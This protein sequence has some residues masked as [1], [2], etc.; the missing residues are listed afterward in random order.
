MLRLIYTPHY[1]WHHGQQ[2]VQEFLREDKDRIGPKGFEEPI[3]KLE[4]LWDREDRMEEMMSER[5][6][7]MDAVAKKVLTQKQLVVYEGYKAGK[8]LRQIARELGRDY[9]TVRGHWH[10]IMKKL[11][12]H[13]SPPHPSY[14]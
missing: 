13:L 10:A 12:K 9:T 3:E 11:L 7:E 6:S 14:M 2:A 1:E 8:S 4:E 5:A